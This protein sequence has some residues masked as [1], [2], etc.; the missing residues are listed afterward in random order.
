MVRFCGTMRKQLLM[1]TYD[2]APGAAAGFL[3]AGRSCPAHP[4]S[5]AA[6]EMERK[7]LD[8]SSNTSRDKY[9]I[10][11][12]FEYRTHERSYETF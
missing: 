7:K 2:M 1:N 4:S 5:I 10:P 12:F 11:S 3:N 9:P 6:G 8:P